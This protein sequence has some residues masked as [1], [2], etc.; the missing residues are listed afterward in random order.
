MISDLPKHKTK[1]VCTIGP[2]REMSLEFLRRRVSS[3]NTQ[4]LQHVAGLFGAD[5]LGPKGERIGVWYSAVSLTTVIM[6][7]ETEVRIDPPLTT[8]INKRRNPD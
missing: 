3:M 2:E 4:F 7:S 1:I 5:V 8:V 6:L